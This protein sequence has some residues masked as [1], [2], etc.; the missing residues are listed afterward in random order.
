MTPGDETAWPG[1]SARPKMTGSDHVTQINDDDAPAAHH[2]PLLNLR[3]PA[4]CVGIARPLMRS[5]TLK[6]QYVWL[7]SSQENLLYTKRA[8]GVSNRGHK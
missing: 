3:C 7:F 8:K 5:W 1:Y 4:L 6:M 2:A